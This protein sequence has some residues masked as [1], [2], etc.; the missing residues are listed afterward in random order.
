MDRVAGPD[1][2]AGQDHAHDSGF[3]DQ[4]A[5]LVAPQGRGHQPR[6]NPV[7]LRAWVAQPGYLDDRGAAE[8]QPRA[9]RQPQQTDAAGGDVLTHLSSRY[10]EARLPQLVVQ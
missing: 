4:I 10:G 7:Q 8:T 1:I 6:L 5:V 9:G 2:S 3:A